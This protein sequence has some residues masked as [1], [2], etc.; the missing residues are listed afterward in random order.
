MFYIKIFWEETAINTCSEASTI[1]DV[2]YHL[3]NRSVDE[4]IIPSLE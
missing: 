1:K 3:K 2:Q 4:G